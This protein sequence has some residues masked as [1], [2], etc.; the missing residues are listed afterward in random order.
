MTSQ[1]VHQALYFFTAFCVCN[2]LT[3][4]GSAQV[5][6][7][8]EV[9]QF[10]ASTTVSVPDYGGAYLGGVNRAAQGSAMRGWGVPRARG[11]GSSVSGGGVSVHV[12][13]IDHAE[14]DARI[15]AEGSSKRTTAADKETLL[16]KKRGDSSASKGTAS[17][18]AIRAELAASDALQE[19]AAEQVFQKGVAAEA[20]KE[21]RLAKVYFQLAA[22]KSPRVVKEKSLA[23]LQAL[24]AIEKNDRPTN[25]G[26]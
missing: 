8:P 24:P 18:S 14:L 21:W 17:L 16:L 20:N 19:E 13:V 5:V 9:H 6:Q 23:R 15:L 22:Q 25:S 1:L 11:F 12:T 10:S 26:S 7:L 4:A 2:C 3:S